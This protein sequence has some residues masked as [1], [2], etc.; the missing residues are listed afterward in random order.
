MVFS[1]LTFLC[2]FFPMVFIIYYLIPSFRAKN[3]LLII[4]SLLFYAYGEPVCVLLMIGSSAMNYMYG[5]LLE[6]MQRRKLVLTLAVLT[7]FFTLGFFKY[8]DMLIDT[9]NHLTGLQVPL[10]QVRLPIGISFFTF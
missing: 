8:A 9:W 4:S 1:S 5:R 10:L 6:K 3:Y 7:N 2:V